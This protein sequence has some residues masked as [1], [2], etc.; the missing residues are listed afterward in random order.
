VAQP[1]S[2]RQLYEKVRS[3]GGTLV[4]GHRGNPAERPENT[5]AS[6]LSAI[7]LGVDLIEC[8][9]HLSS[10]GELVVI[11]DHTLE[12]TTD[13][14]GL[15]R[16]HSSAELRELDAGGGERLPL[17]REVCDLSAEHNVP[18]AIELKQI[19]VPYR[20]I[21]QKVVDL[22]R[23]TNSVDFSAVISFQHRSVQLL[24]QL[25]PR[26][27]AGLL[28]GARPIDPVRMMREANADL[29]APHYGAMDPELVEEMH[30]AGKAVGVWTVDDAAGVLWCRIC[31]PDSVFTN[32]PREIAPL[33]LS[34]D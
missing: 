6:F 14:Q 11:H 26:L 5:L 8:D 7:E 3:G 29:Y 21:E 23:E 20:G 27:Q 4:G 17:L 18:L 19:P 12:R 31:K 22:L 2:V 24:K 10:D 25:E 15:V 34:L 33:L 9:V 1:V 32:R 30:G 16:D 13:G 28:E